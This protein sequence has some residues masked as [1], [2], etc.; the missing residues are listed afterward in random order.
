MQ[1]EEQQEITGAGEVLSVLSAGVGPC[2]KHSQQ[3]SH[4]TEIISYRRTTVGCNSQGRGDLV[5][6]SQQNSGVPM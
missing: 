4:H 2:A 1:K 6:S 3:H 5:Q